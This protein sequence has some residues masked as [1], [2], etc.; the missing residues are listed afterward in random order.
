MSFS[1]FA[2]SV[3]YNPT[4]HHL[5]VVKDGET[6]ELL[7]SAHRTDVNEIVRDNQGCK[8]QPGDLVTIQIRR[9]ALS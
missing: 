6:P 1:S 7:A 8:F 3:S 4:V 5:H 2:P 9:Q